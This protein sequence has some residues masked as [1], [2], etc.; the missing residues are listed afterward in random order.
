[1]PL[2][3]HINNNI[4]IHFTY[5]QTRTLHRIIINSRI[6]I[7]IIINCK[8]G[9]PNTLFFNFTNEMT[10]AE[11]AASASNPLCRRALTMAFTDL[12]P[13]SDCS[14]FYPLLQSFLINFTHIV[15]G[16]VILDCTVGGTILKMVNSKWMS[17]KRLQ[18]T[19]IGN[20]G[21]TNIWRRLH[22]CIEI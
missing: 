1:M 21:C 10:S 3:S 9:E 11:Y 16:R 12:K 20:F 15:R 22:T 2:T 6:L 17:F 8:S 18:Q 7:L 13:I 4:I 5:K 14:I 19:N